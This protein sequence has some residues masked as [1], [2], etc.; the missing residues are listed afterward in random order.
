MDFPEYYMS[1]PEAY[2]VLFASHA[3]KLA[4]LMKIMDDC[5]IST[6]L[7]PV[8]RSKELF[9]M[10]MDMSY[11]VDRAYKKANGI[12]DPE[13]VVSLSTSRE[14]MQEDMRTIFTEEF[15]KYL[16][17]IDSTLENYTDVLNSNEK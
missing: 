1:D 7:P 6:G 13:Y 14:K 15:D 8:G 4:N 11:Q 3:E 9:R 5:V 10:V 12:Q 2:S 17:K 16:S